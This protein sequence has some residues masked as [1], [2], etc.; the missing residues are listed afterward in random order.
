MSISLCDWCGVHHPLMEHVKTEDLTVSKPTK[1]ALKV[2]ICEY[3]LELNSKDRAA[4]SPPMI[5][6]TA[7]DW[8]GNGLVAAVVKVLE[9]K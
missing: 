5:P 8:L 6:P 7:I 3:F 2:A 4:G 9:E 1:N